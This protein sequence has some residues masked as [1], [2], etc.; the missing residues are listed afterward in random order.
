[1]ASPS[2]R[3]EKEMIRNIVKKD[4]KAESFFEEYRYDKNGEMVAL[5]EDV[6]KEYTWNARY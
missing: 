4:E 6:K 3:C 5:P 2:N 1:M